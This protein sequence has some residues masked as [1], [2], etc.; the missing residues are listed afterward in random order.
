MTK[1]IRANMSQEDEAMPRITKIESKKEKKKLRVAAYCRVST[2]QDAQMESLEAQKEHYDQV[3]KSNEDWVYVGLYYQKTF[4][5]NN[6]VRHKNHGDCD[7][8]HHQGTHEAIVSEEQF[9]RVQ[10]IMSQRKKERRID[11]EEHD[12]KKKY[13]M[14]KKLICE[15][16]GSNMRRIKIQGRTSGTYIAWGCAKHCSDPDACHQKSVEEENIKVAF[17]TLTNK[18]M[19]ILSIRIPWSGST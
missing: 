3:I 17:I 5:D 16:C 7:Q 8:Y 2:S 9:N 10:D 13:V 18:L 15:E 19:K 6:L 4:T 1:H 11:S 14:T 12:N